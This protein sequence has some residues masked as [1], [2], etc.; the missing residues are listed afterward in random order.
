M[1][2]H[3]RSTDKAMMTVSFGCDLIQPEI[4]HNVL[5]SDNINYDGKPDNYSFIY[6]L[7]IQAMDIPH[8]PWYHFQ[9]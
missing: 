2:D 7:R 1:T 5:I 4:L 6:N 8:E 9:M 3:V